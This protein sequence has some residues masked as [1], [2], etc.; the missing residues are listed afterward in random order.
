MCEKATELQIKIKE[1]LFE[2][3][4]L[5]WYDKVKES[6][7]ESLLLK[8]EIEQIQ[9]YPDQMVALFT[10]DQLQEL[11]ASTFPSIDILERMIFDWRW[12]KDYWTIFTTFEQLWLAFVMKERHKMVWHNLK[13]E[14]VDELR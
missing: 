2:K 4:H 5:Y 8:K 13:E 1:K 3:M 14:W 11:F 7:N 10:Q 9:K 6:Y 12:E